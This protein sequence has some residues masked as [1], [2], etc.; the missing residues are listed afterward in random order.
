[1]WF[2]N[3]RVFALDNLSVDMEAL[4]NNLNAFPFKDCAK[5]SPASHGWYPPIHLDGRDD[6]PLSQKIGDAVLLC[7]QVEE[8]V[9]PATVVRQQLQEKLD[10]IEQREQRKVYKQ[11]K[12]QL[13]EEIYHTLLMQAFSKKEQLY[14]Y[15]DLKANCLVVNS[16]TPKKVDLVTA[17][18]KK[19]CPELEISLLNVDEGQAK[20]TNWL[21]HHDCPKDI[22]VEDSCLL[23]ARQNA[24]SKVKLSC[25]DLTTDAVQ[26]FLKDG[27]DVSELRLRYQDQV[28]FTLT[29]DFAV[30]QLKFTDQVTALVEDY[31]PDSKAAQILANVTIMQGVLNGL[32][33]CLFLIKD[34]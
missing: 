30:N 21:K 18:L 29:K 15:I 20:L 16:A 13:K 28:Q 10:A 27:C 25:R 24:Q 26:S 7:I 11:E 31:E 12:T 2:K 32:I 23:L 14:A 33:E 22:T 17:L 1:M 5:T 8:K 19:S 6:A 4:E 3:I 9:L 34:S